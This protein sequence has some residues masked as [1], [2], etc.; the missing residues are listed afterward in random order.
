MENYYEP[1]LK[2]GQKYYR[3]H[4]LGGMNPY[5]PA[6]N[7]LVPEAMIAAA[8][9]VGTIDVPAER[10]VGTLTSG[11]SKSFAGNFMPIARDK[12]EFAL[13]W[14]D[15]A[16]SHQ[17]EGIR[18]PVLLYEYMNQYYVQE[19][20]KR[21][22]VLKFFK[23]VSVRA[24]VKRILPEKTDDP[25]V[26]A[27][28][29]S[30]EFNRN[31]GMIFL[32]LT[33]PGAYGEFCEL[34]GK[35]MGEKWD[36]DTIR[37]TRTLFYQFQRVFT[38]AGGEKTHVSAGDA[39]LACMRV[40]GFDYISKLT[41][42]DMKKMMLRVW[43]E[44]TLQQEESKIEM[45]LDPE[46]QGQHVL[47]KFL[48][49]KKIKAAFLY[50]KEG[51][52]SVWVTSHEMARA[53]IQEKF[54]GKVETVSY[55]CD[56]IPGIQE[57]V[58][59]AIRE[60]A[61][62]IFATSA[63]MLDACLKAAV[64]APD[65]AFM[66]CSLNK[67]HR[68]VRAYYPRMYEAKYVAGAIA[69]ALCENGKVGYI[70]KYPIYGSIAEINAFAKGLKMT[71]PAAKLYLEWASIEGTHHLPQKMAEQGIQLISMQDYQ[72]KEK[73]IRYVY[74]LEQVEN[75]EF[76]P[77]VLPV[78]NWEVYYE[79]ILNSMLNGTYKAETEKTR[80]SLMYYWGLSSGAVQL[81]FAERLPEGVRYLGELLVR[82][83]S[84]GICKPFYY[85][86]KKADG[87][88]SWDHLERTLDLDEILEMDS[89]EDNI[90]GE[91]PKYETLTLQAQRLVDV[92]G[93]SSA[94]TSS[95]LEASSQT[96]KN[97]G[98]ETE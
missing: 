56:R 21:V 96:G 85:P 38:A 14:K 83:I 89:L 31:T 39:L 59:A 10:I 19:G 49:K 79:W 63:E 70:C 64:D 11:R 52:A 42:S 8:S 16:I 47:S 9:S 4:M 91:I 26:I 81:L 72:D 45:K 33:E 24:T 43:E 12:T 23:A 71:N 65:V 76:H 50:M 28:Y 34:M 94:K 35:R 90:V 2:A 37:K 46:E 87:H 13:K 30:L 15:L 27:Y 78:W 36:D 44:I 55:V 73:G 32:I 97:T 80:R 92:I 25:K 74:G 66:N 5:L 6:L 41:D 51:R 82:S 77:L 67:P 93:I 86:V 60:G 18:D 75:G 69:G 40:Y 68:Y 1:A 57:K 95:R 84:E 88:L 62:V 7:E 48:A 53:K 17:R 20:N 3:F 29:E 54:D 22:S 98:E 58:D 61:D